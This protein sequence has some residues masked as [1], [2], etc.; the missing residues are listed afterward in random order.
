MNPSPALRRS[1]V[2]L[3]A[4]VLLAACGG[5]VAQPAGSASDETGTTRS[6]LEYDENLHCLIPWSYIT[7][8]SGMMMYAWYDPAVGYFIPRDVCANHGGPVVCPY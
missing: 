1:L 3:G 5:D 7:C 6:P 8:Q 2:V 4:S